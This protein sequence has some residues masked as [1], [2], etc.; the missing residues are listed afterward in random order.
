ML[1][2]PCAPTLRRMWAEGAEGRQSWALNA[3]SRFRSSL[4]PWT[5]Q[6]LPEAQDETMIVLFG[7]TQ[8]GKTTLLLELLGIAKECL[9]HVSEVLR[10]GRGVGRSATA[11]PMIYSESLD[12]LWQLDGHKAGLDDEGLRRALA[13][14]RDDVEAGVAISRPRTVNIPVHYFDTERGASPRVRILD[15]PGADPANGNEAKYVRR[16]AQDYA[17]LADLIILITRADDLGFLKPWNLTEQ[18]GRTLDWTLAPERFCIVTS[19]AFTLGTLRD[20]LS[21]SRETR[22]LSAL[23]ARTAE[24]IRRFD[25]MNA[26]VLPPI[27]PLDF[28][29]S[30]ADTPIQRRAVVQPLLVELRRELRQRIEESAQPLGRLRQARNAYQ[31]TLK[32]Q[33]NLRKSHAQAQKENER[34]VQQTAGQLDNWYRQSERRRERLNILPDPAKVDEACQ[35]LKREINKILDDVPRR[36]V[37]EITKKRLMGTYYL[38]LRGLK[39]RSFSLDMLV[40]ETD[41]NGEL[42]RYVIDNFNKVEFASQL[43]AFFRYFLKRI[44]DHWFG[45]AFHNFEEDRVRLLDSMEQAHLWTQNRLGQAFENAADA[46]KATLADQ[47][48]RMERGLRS[49]ETRMKR[50]AAELVAQQAEITKLAEE[51]AGIERKLEEDKARATQFNALLRAALFDDLRMRREGLAREPVPARQFMRLLEAVSVCAHAREVLEPFPSTTK[52]MP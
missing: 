23:R 5:N 50:L 44:E 30:W 49:V 24:Q 3:Y 10:G 39:T 43:A 35:N 22:N 27:Y 46:H 6:S 28:G 11:T 16:A 21:E 38:F 34:A 40:F 13:Q 48:K 33:E 14:I 26:S 25:G 19:Y 18:F 41:E 15:L 12:E 42:L 37:G 8:V 2:Q 52:N 45:G 7:P 9:P 32:V 1:E 36:F 31:V 51:S 47:R 4:S 29:K 20:W 17:P